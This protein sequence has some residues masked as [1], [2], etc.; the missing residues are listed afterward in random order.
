VEWE[1][2]SENDYEDEDDYEDEEQS[3]LGHAHS[4]AENRLAVTPNPS[5]APVRCSC[6]LVNGHGYGRETPRV[7]SIS[8]EKASIIW[9]ILFG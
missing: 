1:K 3:P 2:E 7:F 8:R 9:E 5:V 4:P 6:G